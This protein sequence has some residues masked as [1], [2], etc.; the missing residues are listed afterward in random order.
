MK[1]LFLGI[2]GILLMS[3]GVE[4]TRIT[5]VKPTAHYTGSCPKTLQIYGDYKLR[6]PAMVNYW[7]VFS[8]GV[9][10]GSN[11]PHPKGPGRHKIKIHRTFTQDFDGWVRLRVSAVPLQT[12]FSPR[13]QVKV[14]CTNQGGGQSGNRIQSIQLGHPTP[15]LIHCPGKVKTRAKITHK[16]HTQIRYRF[17]RNDG[18]KSPWK[19]I[20]FLN[21]GTH[22]VQYLWNIHHNVDRLYRLEIRYRK[23]GSGPWKTLH[24][25]WK[26]F[27]VRCQQQ[28]NPPLVSAVTLYALPG[29]YTGNCPKNILFKGKIKTTRAGVVKYRWIRSDGWTSPVKTLHASHAGIYPVQRYWTIHQSTPQG[30]M[31]IRILGLHPTISPPAHFQVSCQQPPAIL[32]TKALVLPHHYQ[33]ECPVDLQVEGRF[34][35]TKAGTV[36][37]R[38]LRSDGTQSPLKIYHAPS[39][40]WFSV[41]EQLHV[42]ADRHGWVKL[43]IYSPTP[44]LSAPAS[45]SV[46]CKKHHAAEEIIETLGGALLGQMISNQSGQQAAQPPS[47][48]GEE[49][50]GEP[51]EAPKSQKQPPR[52]EAAQPPKKRA[53][54]KEEPKTSQ[55]VS[56][57]DRDGDGLSDRLENTL[58]ERFRPYYLFAKG[59]KWLPSDPLYQLRHATVRRHD[60]LQG[61]DSLPQELKE[62][63]S[64][65]QN[66]LGLLECTGSKE[67]AGLQTSEYALD[68]NDSLRSDPGSGKGG[69]W[70][71]AISTAAGLYG[72]VV[73]EKGKIRIEYWQFFPYAEVSENNGHEGDWQM[74]SLRYDPATDKL[75][76]V[77]HRVYGQQLCFDLRQGRPVP[78]DETT[79]EYRGSEYNTTLPPIDPF[80]P[81]LHPRGWQNRAVRFFRSE[82]GLHPV[83]YVQKGS[84][85]FW[86]LP[87]GKFGSLS[88]K[89]EQGWGNSYLSTLRG[90]QANLGEWNRP[91][92]GAE[93]P[94]ALILR[95]SGR[96]GAAHL[97]TG[98]PPHGPAWQC[99]WHLPENGSTEAVPNREC[100]R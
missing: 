66:P 99:D 85:A 64:L 82:G 6:A 62:C 95:Y 31:K 34:R 7:F 38:F 84:H 17:V 23:I 36:K 88:S 50:L 40:G 97:E 56:E 53:E 1:R 76:R 55:T 57:E 65:A 24:S 70:P 12:T 89:P 78:L 35:I 54:T 43:K 90:A 63:S 49:L 87:E 98:T 100:R 69:D 61:S 21:A 75:E 45:Y 26:Q 48:D 52:R 47:Q 96:W 3:V 41:Y 25:A 13:V 27:R 30:W 60:Y 22:T 58:L 42:T 33:G 9:K 93:D 28:P 67:G 81:E 44:K 8:D 94:K 16:G 79:V 72:H 32:Q 2:L 29:H 92:P 83:V 10:R 68:L 46:D 73:P 4:A 74:L 20:N 51:L 80:S 14:R 15:S 39:A 5:A 11:A 59:E 86:P 37:Y 91:L 18:V 77:C 19:T 71:A